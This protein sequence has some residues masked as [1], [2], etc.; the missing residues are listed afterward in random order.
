MLTIRRTRSTWNVAGA[1]A[2]LSIIAIA[3]R[4]ASAQDAHTPGS[5]LVT[6]R[7]SSGA[8]LAGAQ[9]SVRGTTVRGITDDEG[10]VQL[11]S[12]PSGRVYLDVRR[13]G[14]H[15]VSVQVPVEASATAEVTVTLAPTAQQLAPVLV[16]GEASAFPARMA[17]FFQRR[18]RGIG[19]FLTRADIELG[20]P[21]ELTDVFRRLPSVE[22]VSTQFIQH[23]VRLRGQRCAPLVWMDGFPLSA[24]EFDLDMVSPES[25]EAI[26][27]YSGISE[28]PAEFVGPR[29]LGSCGA[30]LIW[31]RH[32][33]LRPRKVKNPVSAAELA[34]LV[35]ALKVY[36]AEEVD[37]PAHPDTSA[38][39]RPIYPVS[40]YADGINGQVTAEYVVDTTGKVM[41]E[42]FNAITSTDPALTIAVRNALPAAVYVPARLDGHLV[43]QVVHQPFTFTVDSTRTP[44]S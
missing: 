35:S 43:K 28:V 42:T 2:S 1:I 44:R 15:P 40:L 33:E 36:T 31:S 41:L 21:N 6:V 11:S 32:A 5:I 8:G 23:A 39:V 20:H 18:E 3:P 29:G 27:V 25:V 9:L 12:V 7:D 19:R 34:A 22:I 10:K 4:S 17:G 37:V 24:A 16:L 13:L 30:V 38:P 26:E 14:F